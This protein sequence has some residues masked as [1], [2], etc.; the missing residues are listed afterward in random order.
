[1]L[2]RLAETPGRF[3]GALLLTGPSAARLEE[4]ARRLAAILLCPSEDPG[5]RCGSCRRAI[6]GLHPDLTV[7]QPQGVQIR[8]DGVREAVGFGA[9]KPYESS[10][11]VAIVSRAEMLGAEAANALLK[12]LEEPG[13]HF[14]WILTTTRAEALLPTVRSRCVAVPLPRESR[15]ERT[16][17]WVSR[18]FPAEDAAELVDIDLEDP[19]Q[20]AE[21]LE[22]HRAWRANILA[23]LEAGLARRAVAPLLLLAEAL[24]QADADRARLFPEI[25]AD[26]AVASAGSSELLRHR[27]AA[28]G[29]LNLARTVPAEALRRAA[30]KAADAPPDNRRGNKRLHY[31][32]VLL[33]LFASVPLSS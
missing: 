7:V 10:R 1:M 33:D 29:I 26:A 13:R 19:R 3:P 22:E 17:A 12:T 15:A 30:V 11:R 32:S 24:A 8:I 23:A 25:L 18:G 20:A 21:V 9:G 31:E 14:H 2:E 28:A 27:S 4:E 16:E 6:A 5:W